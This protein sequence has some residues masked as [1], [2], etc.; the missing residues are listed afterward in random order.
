MAD[1][2]QIEAQVGLDFESCTFTADRP[3]FPDGS[4]Y[5][6]SQES[7]KGSPLAE[8]IFT[9]PEV[10][11]VLVA[12]NVVTVKKGDY[13]DWVPIARKVGSMVRSHLASG[14]PWLA[15]DLKD[16]LP[17]EGEIRQKLKIL[18]DTEINPAVASH[19]GFVDLVDVKGNTVY[20][21][22][23]GGCQGCGMAD[24]TLKHGI[25]AMIREQIPEVGEI[26]DTTDHAGGRNPFYAPAKG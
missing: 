2:I 18:L 19:G 13:N 4:Y 25:E 1:E 22:M 16:R 14:Q 5:F 26:L 7:A 11:G 10:T 8:E 20:I 9:I 21:Q 6:S 3:V 12:G 15:P 24:V 23:G 17:D